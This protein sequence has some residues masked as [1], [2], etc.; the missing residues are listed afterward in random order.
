MQ[1]PREALS[2]VLALVLTTL[3]S[4]TPGEGAVVVTIQP[5]QDLQS[6]VWSVTWNS[7][8]GVNRNNVVD[9]GFIEPLKDQFHDNYLEY[10]RQVGWFSVGNFLGDYFQDGGDFAYVDGWYSVTSDTPGWLICPFGN[11]GSARDNVFFGNNYFGYNDPF[12]TSGAFELTIPGGR[13]TDYNPGIYTS[14][15]NV[16]VTVSTTPV[17]EPTGL[18]LFGIAASLLC[19]LRQRR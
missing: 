8:V 9:L 5:G 12:P 3:L 7:L 15:P 14:N 17:P 4:P 1:P 18:S 16:T 19:H 13:I 11:L 6:V 10:H 2:K